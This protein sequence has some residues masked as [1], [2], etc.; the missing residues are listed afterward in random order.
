MRRL[1]IKSRAVIVSACALLALAGGAYAYFTSAGTGTG[2]GSVGAAS[3]ITVTG[4][5]STALYPG[6]SSSVTF[7]ANNPSPGHEK[8]QTITLTGVRACTGTGSSWTGT[9]GAGSCSA[10]GTEQTTC[11]SYDTSAS[12]TTDNFSMPVVTVNTDYPSGSGQA[13]SPNGSIAMN[14]LSSSQNSCQNASLTLF[15]TTT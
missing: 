2:T 8:L 9:Y 3:A 11:E 6:T 7:T 5:A 4:T 1:K 13:V 10:S 15:F 14:D 12:S